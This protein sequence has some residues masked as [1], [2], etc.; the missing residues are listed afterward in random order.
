MAQADAL[1]QLANPRLDIALHHTKPRQRQGDILPSGPAAQQRRRLENGAN[2]P[3]FPAQ[4]LAGQRR[5]IPAI[6]TNAAAIRL[7]QQADAARRLIYRR[8][9][10]PPPR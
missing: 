4:R 6:D 10:A 7:L 8:R 2:R 9:S 3:P 1:Q 5:Q